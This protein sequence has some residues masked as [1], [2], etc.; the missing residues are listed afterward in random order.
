[1]RIR[2]KNE[3]KESMPTVTITPSVAVSHARR[4]RDIFKTAIDRDG[5]SLFATV[6]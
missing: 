2:D 6:L 5:N 4:G 3:G 1:M